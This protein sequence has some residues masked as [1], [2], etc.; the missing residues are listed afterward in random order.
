MAR[1]THRSKGGKKLYVKRDRRGRIN[2]VQTYAR[3][4]RADLRRKSKAEL[5][6]GGGCSA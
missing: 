6:K 2:D 4:H 5:R 3:A 1:T